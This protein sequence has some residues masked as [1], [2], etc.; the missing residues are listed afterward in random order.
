MKPE[1]TSAPQAIQLAAADNVAVARQDLAPGSTVLV[2]G[3]AVTVSEPIAS[4]HKLA[5]RPIARGEPVLKYGQGIGVAT[6]DIAAG[7]HVHVHNMGMAES[8]HAHAAGAG[9]R[10]TEPAAT[11]LTFEGYVRADGRVATRNYLGVISSVNC[12]AT[13]CR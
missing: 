11:P 1:K 5:L 10:P 4:G 6:A 7:Q 9:Y 2:N 12:S 13:V 3:L 8:S